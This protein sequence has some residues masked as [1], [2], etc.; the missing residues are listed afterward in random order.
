MDVMGA[1]GE[2]EREKIRLKKLIESKERGDR[3]GS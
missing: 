3:G 2:V 1:G